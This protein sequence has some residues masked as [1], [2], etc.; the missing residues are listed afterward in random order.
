MCRVGTR[1]QCGEGQSPREG[2]WS[3]TQRSATREKTAVLAVMRLKELW[4]L[5]DGMADTAACATVADV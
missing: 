1:A 2:H 4:D 3:G 5:S